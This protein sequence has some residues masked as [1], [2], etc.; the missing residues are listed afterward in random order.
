V[1]PDGRAPYVLVVLT[2]GVADAASARRLI[3]DLT[4]LIHRHASGD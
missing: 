4:R 2:R 1:Y 3:V